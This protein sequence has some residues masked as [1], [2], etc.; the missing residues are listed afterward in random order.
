VR[1]RSTH[2]WFDDLPR[3]LR[4]QRDAARE[5]AGLQEH[6]SRSP[7]RLRYRLDVDV[8]AYDIVRRVTID[9]V[10]SSRGDTPQVRTDGPKAS[11][12]RYA[13]GAL[14]MWFPRDPVDERWVEEDGLGGLVDRIRIHLWQEETWRRTG[15]WVGDE[16]GH[17]EVSRR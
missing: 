5:Q 16:A 9:F 13:G 4:F 11:P 10:P 17:N 14:C 3:R 7:R 1:R 8:P 2:C 15:L 12:H 6:N